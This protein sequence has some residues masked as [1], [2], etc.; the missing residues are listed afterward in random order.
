MLRERGGS[1]K[2]LGS[3]GKNVSDSFF[4]DQLFLNIGGQ[5]FDTWEHKSVAD[6]KPA[7]L[8]DDFVFINSDGT[9]GCQF[10]RFS[11]DQSTAQ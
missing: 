3:D 2:R 5:S 7:C 8:F 1:V 10:S 6:E 9:N 11:V 4:P